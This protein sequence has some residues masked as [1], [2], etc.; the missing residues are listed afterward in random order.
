MAIVPKKTLAQPKCSREYLMSFIFLICCC[1]IDVMYARVPP[2]MCII[3]KN[4]TNSANLLK[5]PAIRN[6][7]SKIKRRIVNEVT[8]KKK[9]A[10]F[11]YGDIEVSR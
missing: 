5:S 4:R 10:V 1:L 9:I 7:I 11:L 3:A 2:M 6:D 8:S